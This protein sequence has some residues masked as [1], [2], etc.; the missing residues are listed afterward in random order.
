MNS[1]PM[2]SAYKEEHKNEPNEDNRI[3]SNEP[4]STYEHT[5]SSRKKMPFGLACMEHIIRPYKLLER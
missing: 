5:P 4:L 3:A 1:Q 2:C